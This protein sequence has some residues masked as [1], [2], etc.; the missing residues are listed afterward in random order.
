[1]HKLLQILRFF[2]VS[3]FFVIYGHAS[4]VLPIPIDMNSTVDGTL[5]SES[6]ISPNSGNASEYY[7]FT[8]TEEKNVI[9]SL[10]SD[11]YYKFYL[12][13]GNESVIKEVSKYDYKNNK[14]VMTLAQG[15]YKIDVTTIFNDQLGSFVLSFKENIIATSSITLDSVIEGEWTTSSGLSSRSNNYTNY[16]SFNLI[17]TIDISIEVDGYSNKLFLLDSNNSTL[18]S[19]NNKIIKTLNPGSYTIDVTIENRYSNHAGVFLLKFKENNIEKTEIEINS[20][21][22]GSWKLNSGISPNSKQRTN[23]YTFTLTE[24]KNIVLKLESNKSGYIYILDENG[25]I[26]ERTYGNNIFTQTLDFGTYTVDVSASSNNMVGDYVLTLNENI[27]SHTNIE[28]NNTIE[29]Q[30][31]ENSGYSPRT[32][33][34]TNYYTFTLNES[35]NILI[36]MNAN[37][38]EGFYLLDENGTRV[39]KYRQFGR[40]FV[41]RLEAGTYMIDVTMYNNSDIGTYTLSLTENIIESKNI[42]LNS[43][44]SDIFSSNDGISENAYGNGYA[45]RYTF[46]LDDTKDILIDVNSTQKLFLFD[47]NGNM[48]DNE[49]GRIVHTLNKGDYT[50]E[51]AT[52]WD[53]QLDSFILTLRENIILSKPIILN[54]LTQ[55]S[56]TTLSGVSRYGNYIER[57]TFNI[58]ETTE[59]F[60]QL[61]SEFN[62]SIR[63]YSENRYLSRYSWNDTGAHMQVELE[64]GTYT[65]DVIIDVMN[66]VHQ[67]GDY[68][69]LVQADVE[70]ALSVE[71]LKIESTNVYSSI[72]TWEKG[73]SDTV[74]YKIYLN[75]KLVA[76]VNASENSYILSGLKQNSDYT[77]SIVAYNSAGESEAVNG[78]FKTK[79]DDYAWLVPVYHAVLY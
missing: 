36:D 50:I 61:N 52:G 62:H 30:W 21:V 5:T 25:T 37:S 51:I 40:I 29:G 75:D 44:I 1:M 45:K 16:Y 68:T 57:Y 26:I 65:I 73:S 72:I 19:G 8:L 23:Y 2:S 3:F 59:V 10:E 43:S 48:L 24:S 31:S 69:L 6:D 15:S 33:N 67:V 46:K 77:Y 54:Q 17:E 12:L 41:K 79:K 66:E 49:Y 70:S 7:T 42:N 56:W 58:S 22:N 64:K 27:I 14:I 55:G 78:T 11:I 28:L 13:D 47:S 34:Y 35:R 71:N 4:I 18:Y 32:K 74:G 63:L 76:D 39:Y 20:I 9:I 38:D 53:K 60:I